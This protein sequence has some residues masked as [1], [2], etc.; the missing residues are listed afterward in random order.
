M[1]RINLRR[2]E[3]FQA[4]YKQGSVSG[5]ARS[6][7]ITQPSVSRMLKDFELDLGFKLFELERGKMRPTP[8]ADRLHRESVPMFEHVAHI[9]RVAEQLK[10]G[11]E[12]LLRV[13]VTP[14]LAFDILPEAALRFADAYPQIKLHLGF[15][16]LS[17]Q[18]SA[19]L[20]GEIDLGIANIPKPEPG[21]NQKPLGEGVFVCLVPEGDKLAEASVIR[22]ED[23][24]RRRRVTGEESGPLVRALFNSIDLKS[25][26]DKQIVTSSSIL[27]A[28]LTSLDRSIMLVDLFTAVSCR[29][30]NIIKPFEKCIRFEL[31]ALYLNIRPLSHMQRIFVKYFEETLEEFG[32]NHNVY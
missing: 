2:M 17:D 12:G 13:A 10:G 27:A 18:R 19:L 28:R 3:I 4:V 14:F 30:G 24:M 26:Q 20:R 7:N 11:Q 23:L 32:K 5:A 1:A 6:L 22:T 31:N 25:E 21:I 15:K 29:Q 8:E 9:S 16:S